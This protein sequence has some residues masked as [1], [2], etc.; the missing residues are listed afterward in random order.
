MPKCRA[1]SSSP[2]PWRCS[3]HGTIASS[4]D[5]RSAEAAVTRR[6]PPCRRHLG[7]R[8][9]RQ[10]PVEHPDDALAQV[11]RLDRDD[12]RPVSGQLVGQFA[13]VADDDVDGVPARPG[14]RGRRGS[15]ATARWRSS[16]ARP[17]RTRT[18]R[19]P[20]V[21]R[22]R[23]RQHQLPA[24]RGP[25]A[26]RSRRPGPP[27]APGPRSWTA[28]TTPGGRSRSWPTTY[29]CPARLVSTQGSIRRGTPGRPASGRRSVTGARS[30]VA[31]S[32]GSNAGSA[33]RTLGSTPTSDS[34]SV[35]TP[36]A[37]SLTSARAAG[38]A[39]LACCQ[40]RLASQDGRSSALEA[41]PRAGRRRRGRSGSRARPRTRSCGLPSPRARR[42]RAGP[43]CRARTSGRT[44]RSSR[45][46][47]T[48]GTAAR[49]CSFVGHDLVDSRQMTRSSSRSVRCAGAAIDQHATRARRPARGKF[50][51]PVARGACAARTRPVGRR[52]GARG[53]GRRGPRV[54]RRGPRRGRRAAVPWPTP[55]SSASPGRA[56]WCC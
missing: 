52:G 22:A 13:D 28:G 33:A 36:S 6:S 3:S 42:A 29:Q 9:P 30:R 15:T 38:P 20:L 43:P 11:R 54:P 24:A 2:T 34:S 7:R 23:R 35:S 16:T 41:R 19:H 26:P 10:R 44:P 51:D 1:A 5:R 45:T 56:S 17:G 12:V 4:R 8:P 49:I 46:R 53:R 39:R 21:A 27:A 14:P 25:A 47:R 50:H 32:S 48:A 18:S 37:L 55:R 31:A 40:T